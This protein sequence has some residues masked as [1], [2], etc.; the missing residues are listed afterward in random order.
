MIPAT[1]SDREVNEVPKSGME[2][3]SPE[4]DFGA[5]F[6]SQ[7]SDTIREGSSV[8]HLMQ[9]FSANSGDPGNPESQDP[10]MDAPE[11]CPRTPSHQ[12]PGYIVSHHS[13][14]N[15]GSVPSMQ[16]DVSE[17]YRFLERLGEGGFGYVTRV[18]EKCTGKHFALKT[19]PKP[20][21]NHTALCDRELEV[22]RLL[23]H[24]YIVRL[25]QIFRDDENLY[26][27]ME[28]CTG[29]DLNKLVW[30][31][32]QTHRGVCRSR[33][34][35]PPLVARYLWQML[36]GLAYLHSFGMAHR[37][38]K[39]ANYMLL[40]ASRQAPI[41]LVDFGLACC[42]PSGRMWGRVGSCHYAAPEVFFS[43]DGYTEK[44]DMWGIG[45]TICVLVTATYPFNG[46]NQTDIL[47]RSNEAKYGFLS[48]RWSHHSPLLKDLV[49][50]FLTRDPETRPSAREAME[51][52]QWLGKFNRD[53]PAC[54]VVH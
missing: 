44:C 28:L 16:G 27:V 41:R 53:Q 30:S 19:I 29:P 4:P 9:M 14:R 25:Y 31:S 49:A 32:I 45:V 40:A 21:I 26:L 37:D 3:V 39:A 43:E 2:Q 52:N 34:L 10:K 42:F 22:A 35:N 48:E 51:T 36:S 11:V 46:V 17:V 54:C 1:A 24:R 7:H 18:E 13:L 23:E 15:R 38:I 20:Q 12:L 50:K 8:N 33:G 6:I 47:Q 5:S